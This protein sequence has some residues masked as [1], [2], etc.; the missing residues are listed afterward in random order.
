M[1]KQKFSFNLYHHAGTSSTLDSFL[2]FSYNSLSFWW[3]QKKGLT[4]RWLPHWRPFWF[5]PKH[6]FADFI[7]FWK[8]SSSRL[9]FNEIFTDKTTLNP[10]MVVLLGRKDKSKKSRRWWYDDSWWEKREES[11]FNLSFDRRKLQGF[12][13]I[14]RVVFLFRS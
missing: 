9:K 6:C 2:N 8:I 13:L 3:W 4:L 11:G 12:K 1:S 14:K 7:S 5:L 10:S